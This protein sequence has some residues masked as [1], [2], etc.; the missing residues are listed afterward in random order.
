M[1]PCAR[2]LS[3]V[4]PDYMIPSVVMTVAAMPRTSSGKI[5]RRALPDPEPA[6]RS[7]ATVA[8]RNETEA[9]IAA[10]WREVLDIEVVGIHD[11]FL[12][13]GG[14]SL[15]ATRVAS[16][17]VRDLGMNITITD[18]FRHPTIAALAEAAQQR[19]PHANAAIRTVTDADAITP[20]TAAER[21]LLG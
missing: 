20:M 3:T 12:A 8:P 15:K 21:E 19:A 10:I 11:D 5:D 14:H 17:I 1:T 7:A 2:Y 9:A 18:V 4:L 6:A 13:L 16:R